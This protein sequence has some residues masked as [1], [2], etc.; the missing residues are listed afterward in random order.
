MQNFWT[1]PRNGLILGILVLGSMTA[2]TRSQERTTASSRTTA[3][4]PS[5]PLAPQ[6]TESGELKLPEDFSTWVFVGSNLGI[7]YR[8][9]SAPADAPEKAD[10]SHLKSANFHNVYLNPE[11][12]RHFQKTGEFP[13]KTVLILDVYKA[14]EG[15]PKSVVSRGL[16]PGKRQEIAVAVKNSARPGGVKAN[17]AYY[18]FPPDQKTAKPFPEKACYDC[19]LQHAQTD[20]VWVQFYPTLRA[21]QAQTR[22]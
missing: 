5:A 21:L 16:F 18:D 11:A 1:R 22:K 10:T 19:H 17:W 3:E 12:F 20:N 14:E 4:T 15:A 9:D 13:D 2:I 7:E 6:Y 8:D